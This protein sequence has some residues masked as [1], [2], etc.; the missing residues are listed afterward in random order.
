LEPFREPLRNHLRKAFQ[1]FF[2]I[3]LE[4]VLFGKGPKG[5][6]QFGGQL[7]GLFGR[8][9]NWLGGKVPLLGILNL[10]GLPF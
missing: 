3:G 1:G 8:L 7:E 10:R 2:G 4:G 5:K 9:I 6:G